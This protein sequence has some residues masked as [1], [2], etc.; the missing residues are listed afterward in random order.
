MN[1]TL[2]QF[3]EQYEGDFWKWF[4]STIGDKG[5]WA[6]RRAVSLLDEDFTDGRMILGS[7]VPGSERWFS[8]LPLLFDLLCSLAFEPDRGTNPVQL[9]Y[10]PREMRF[11]CGEGAYE[12]A[13]LSHPYRGVTTLLWWIR[14]NEDFMAQPSSRQQR[15]VSLVRKYLYGRLDERNGQLQKG[16]YSDVTG[17]ALCRVRGSKLTV[18]AFPPEWPRITARVHEYMR[19]ST[20]CEKA[21]IDMPHDLQ[22]YADLLGWDTVFATV[23]K[24][25]AAAG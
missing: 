24:L 21:I 12:T 8:T 13:I 11:S 23:E 14:W 9:R 7:L 6:S 22:V 1:T 19:Q 5:D 10:D 20:A 16:Y 15:L 18:T 25:R 3:N 4:D 17:V 2:E